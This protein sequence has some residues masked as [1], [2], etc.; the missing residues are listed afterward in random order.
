[1]ALSYLCIA[2]LMHKFGKVADRRR[3][4][5]I[6]PSLSVSLP[7]THTGS[8]DSQPPLW[9]VECGVSKTCRFVHVSRFYGLA[10]RSG[11]PLEQR[12]SEWEGQDGD[13]TSAI[14]PPTASIRLGWRVQLHGPSKI[15][16]VRCLGSEVGSD[17]CGG[18]WG[19][20]GEGG[21][22]LGAKG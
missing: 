4:L 19:D 16:D 3:F 20:A 1:M 13:E 6:F 7:C 14:T 12:D 8:L 18:C 11:L 9:C 5:S 17:E 15:E 22:W 2:K 10:T 21:E